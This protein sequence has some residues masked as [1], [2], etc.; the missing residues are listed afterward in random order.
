MVTSFASAADYRRKVPVNTRRMD[1][2]VGEVKGVRAAGV[3]LHATGNRKRQ[4]GGDTCQTGCQPAL[5]NLRFLTNL[6]FNAKLCCM[7][8]SLLPALRVACHRAQNAP[9]TLEVLLKSATIVG[10]AVPTW[11]VIILLLLVHFL[12]T[13]IASPRSDWR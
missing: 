8:V 2:S 9:T 6:C 3:R 1:S 10:Q 7:T 5:Q 4:R 12:L 13:C 11:S